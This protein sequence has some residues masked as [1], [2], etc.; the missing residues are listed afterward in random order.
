MF[1]GTPQDNSD[2]MINKGRSAVANNG[3]A[4]LTPEDVVF[5][6]RKVKNG[7]SVFE[8]AEIY[9]VTVGTISNVVSNKT[10]K[11]Y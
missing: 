11:N 5:I 1:L 10:W 6:R 7:Q 9:D 8:L 2:D 4:K 3:H